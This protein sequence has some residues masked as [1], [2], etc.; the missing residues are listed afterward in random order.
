VSNISIL[1]GIQLY[2]LKR[3]RVPVPFQLDIAASGIHTGGG[4]LLECREILRFL[5]Q[6]R[7][8]CLAEYEGHTVVAKLFIHSDK[9]ETDYAKELAGYEYLYNA[10]VLTPKMLISGPLN[11][12]GFY[13][14]YHY[15]EAAVILQK[16][17]SAV[18]D[19]HSIHSLQKLLAVIAQ[20][21]NAGIVQID[22]HLNNFLL[23]DQQLF[24]IDCGDVVK[25]NHSSS[26][27]TAQIY[28]NLADILSQLPIVYDRLI[29]EFITVYQAG[30]HLQYPLAKADLCQKMQQWRKWRIKKY[31]K[32]STRNCSEFIAEKTLRECR[33]YRREYVNVNWLRFYAQLDEL[34]ESSQ[35]LKDG[36]TATVALADCEG[37]KLVIKRY[38]IKS[39]GHWLSRMWRPSRGWTSWQNAHQLKVL[40]IKTPRPIAVVEKRF[41]WLRHKAFYVSEYEPAADALSAYYQKDEVSAQ[42]LDDFNDLFTAMVYARISHGDLKANNILLTEK[43]LSLIDLDAMKFHRQQ[44][45]FEKAF[46]RDCLR[47]LRNWRPESKVYQQFKM[48][49][50][51]LPAKP[52]CE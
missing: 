24:T 1:D 42:H 30:S 5:P 20:M 38:N 15:I 32:K 4:A 8:V 35:R 22:L 19:E 34:V 41:G 50:N 27:K 18:P 39:F 17:I 47:F 31:L 49:L 37:R 28:K 7:L 25:L 21:H 16:N 51:N 14:L 10:K 23:T 46:E 48:L 33:V 13:V 40:G 45:D 9:A 29:N 6:R 12:A 26:R 52:V 44:I 36:N 2:L 11:N 3:E 43:G